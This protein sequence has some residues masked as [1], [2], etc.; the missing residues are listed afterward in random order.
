MRVISGSAGGILLSSG[1]ADLRPTT[2]RARE[3]I[4]SSLAPVIAGARVL[5]LFAGTGA[6]G[7]EALSRG[8]AEAWF[9]DRSTEAARAI[10]EN[11]RR[12]HLQGE[13][14][15]KNVWD[16]LKQ[17]RGGPVFD[18]IFADPPYTKHRDMEDEALRLLGPGGP[19]DLLA[20]GGTL[21]L[22]KY[23]TPPLKDGGDW[24]I[25]RSRVY[26]DAEVVF[27]GKQ[28]TPAG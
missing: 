22:E 16:F 8:A 25:L 21:I 4:F 12:A 10:R 11:L 6:L 23:R 9:V 7:I 13:I 20:P 19:S 27:L 1:S 18:L 2:D 17:Y 3:A 26:G 5:D 28:A 14:L 24:T 15:Q